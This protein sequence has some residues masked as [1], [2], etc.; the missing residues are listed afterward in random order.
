MYLQEEEVHSN[1]ATKVIP[2]MSLLQQ[3]GT[4]KNGKQILVFDNK[5]QPRDSMSL[6]VGF[7]FS[8]FFFKLSLALHKTFSCG[9]RKK[10]LSDDFVFK[11]DCFL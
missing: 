9:G 6:K 3:R 8:Y 5:N 11:Q 4:K 7:I 10:L 2:K 1:A